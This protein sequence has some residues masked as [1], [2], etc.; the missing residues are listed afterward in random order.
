[1]NRSWNNIKKKLDRALKIDPILNQWARLDRE[2]YDIL[3]I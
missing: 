3:F 2:K 1:M